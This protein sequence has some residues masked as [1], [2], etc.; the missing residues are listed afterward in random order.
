MY[1]TRI[2]RDARTRW[3]LAQCHADF[4]RHRVWTSGASTIGVPPVGAPCAGDGRL[5]EM[6][7][8][9]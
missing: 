2:M 3:A 9:P 6:L 7:F 1:P 5:E 8:G 4:N